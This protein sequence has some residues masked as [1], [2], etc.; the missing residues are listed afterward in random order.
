ML[1]KKFDAGSPV[2]PEWLD[3]IQNP[4]YDV[5][6]EEVG[7]LPLPPGYEDKQQW[8]T[9]EVYGATNL[10]DLRGWN[11]NVVVKALPTY[12]SLTPGNI[13]S[14]E[15]E[16]LNLKADETTGVIFVVPHIKNDNSMIVDLDVGG[17]HR[18]LTLKRDEIALMYASNFGESIALNALGFVIPS[19]AI[20]RFEGLECTRLTLKVG[21]DRVALIDAIELDGKKELRFNVFNDA[22]ID[23]YAPLKGVSFNCGE[24]T[25]QGYA[26][27]SATNEK[28]RLLIRNKG[29]YNA[30]A[31]EY[32]SDTDVMRQG[33][34]HATTGSTSIEL[35]ETTHATVDYHKATVKDRGGYE[36]HILI[37]K[38]VDD[39]LNVVESAGT[40]CVYYADQSLHS[41][42][43]IKCVISAA[44]IKK[45]TWTDRWELSA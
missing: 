18:E 14:I 24:H 26:S 33:H 21:E 4:S 5:S 32:D 10:V 22:S 19:S 12:T 1:K 34:A 45:Y 37:N 29:M 25:D 40:L 38:D 3:A 11:R 36:S 43:P 44:G 15:P 6:K 42:P 16:K 9:F 2:T 20:G 28:G 35:V 31:L 17:N 41:E 23:F 8:K 7:H 13:K 27:I 30:N 39:N